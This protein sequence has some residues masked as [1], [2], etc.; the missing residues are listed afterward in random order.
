MFDDSYLAYRNR[1]PGELT[2]PDTE[3]VNL[4]K[5]SI[6]FAPTI[7]VASDNCK[8]LVFRNSG[9]TR[10]DGVGRCCSE[11]KLNNGSQVKKPS[12]QVRKAVAQDACA[13]L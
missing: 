5:A 6:G 2:G 10:R 4:Y 12:I 8:N 9:Q 11:K 13:K 7:K 1:S 3:L